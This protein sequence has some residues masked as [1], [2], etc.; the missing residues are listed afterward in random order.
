MQVDVAEEN[1]NAEE[2]AYTVENPSLDVEQFASSYSG[3]AKLYRLTYVADHCPLLR[4]EAL[5]M[6]IQAVQ[7][8]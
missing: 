1:E 5:K 7:V 3:L 2:E 6:A 8:K 4:V